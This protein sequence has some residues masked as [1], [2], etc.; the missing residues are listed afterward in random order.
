[1]RTERGLHRLVTFADAVVAIAITLL[2][3]PLVEI[4]G[5]SEGDSV[6]RMLSDHIG[7]LWAFALSFVV[8][9]R[10]WA[11]HHQTFEQV[12]AYD[13]GLVRLTLAW[14]L[15][16][17]FMPFPTELIG[18]SVARGASPLYIGTLLASSLA[19]AGT[20]AWL[21][22]HPELRVPDVPDGAALRPRWTSAALLAISFVISLVNPVLGLWTLLLLFLTRRVDRLVGRLGRSRAA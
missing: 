20:S 14:L 6:A 19:L 9:A 7:Q 21:R 3:L 15:T 16:I 2:V 4:P 12:A 17:V 13:A 8:I 11:A 18:S 1:M 22:A 10:F 5:Q